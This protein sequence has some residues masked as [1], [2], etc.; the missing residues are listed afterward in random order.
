MVLRKMA[1][2]FVPAVFITVTTLIAFAAEEVTIG[3]ENAVT[4]PAGSDASIASPEVPSPEEN[5]IQWVWG[6]VSGVDEAAG[7]ITL[8]YLD[9]ET[10]QEKEMPLSVDEETSFENIGGLSEIKFKDTLSIDYMVT[11]DGKNVARNIGVE[12]P[13]SSS[14]APQQGEEET[15]QSGLEGPGGGSTSDPELSVEE[16]LAQEGDASQGSRLE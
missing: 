1:L 15:G 4:V 10:D 11:A 13:D 6:E 14:V 3:V 5:D 2:V 12:S 9:Y 7:T 8:K 16:N